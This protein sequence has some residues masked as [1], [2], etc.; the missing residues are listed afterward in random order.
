MDKSKNYT[1]GSTALMN[2]SLTV[3]V[4]EESRLHGSC[5]IRCGVLAN[6]LFEINAEP[7]KKNSP[8]CVGFKIFLDAVG[9]NWDAEH[10]AFMPNILAEDVEFNLDLLPGLEEAEN[11]NE[12]GEE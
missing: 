9:V 4:P 5:R 2:S 10:G 8:D 11:D 1:K 6:H 3:S 7:E 12:E